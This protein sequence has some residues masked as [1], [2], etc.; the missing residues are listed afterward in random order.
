MEFDRFNVGEPFLSYESD[1]LTA[2]RNFASK[3]QTAHRGRLVWTSQN[4]AKYKMRNSKKSAKTRFTKAKNHPEDL[5]RNQ[6]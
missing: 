1:L 3:E 6:P 4:G 2:D 5:L